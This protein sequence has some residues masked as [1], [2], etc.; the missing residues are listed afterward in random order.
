MIIEAH[1]EGTRY[2]VGVNNIA[3]IHSKPVCRQLRIDYVDGT[4]TDF[5]DFNYWTKSVPDKKK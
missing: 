4:Y 5:I 1:I 2:Q 3:F